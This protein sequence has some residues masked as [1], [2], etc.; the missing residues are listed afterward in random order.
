MT[1]ATCK[2]RHSIRGPLTVSESGFLTVTAG[3]MAAG[4]KAHSTGSLHRI[5]K[6]ERERERRD[7]DTG[8]GEGFWNLRARPSDK[9]S[10]R[11]HLY[12]SW[13]VH[14]L[15]NKWV[16]L[17]GPFSS[18][19]HIPRLR[20]GNREVTKT[21]YLG[22]FFLK[23]LITMYACMS[24][25]HRG[26]QISLQ[27]VMSGHMVTGTELRMSSQS[28]LTAEPSLYPDWCSFKSG[29]SVASLSYL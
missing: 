2:R 27:V 13:T 4:R 1:K 15:W 21:T 17:W 20:E 25:D 23:D 14:Q 16:S 8:P 26:H 24:A 29:C 3:T 6:L 5:Y 19:H 18:E 11:S 28:S 7:R 12:S 22:W 10:L 9:S